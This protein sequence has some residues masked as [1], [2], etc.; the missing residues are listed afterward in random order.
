MSRRAASPARRDLQIKINLIQ[1]VAVEVRRSE[2]LKSPLMKKNQVVLTRPLSC[3][4]WCSSSLS[5]SRP[6]SGS[7]NSLRLLERKSSSK[8]NS[9]SSRC[10][11]RRAWVCSN[12]CSNSFAI[13]SISLIIGRMIAAPSAVTLLFP[14]THVPT[15]RRITTPKVLPKE[16]TRKADSPA[17]VI[18]SSPQTTIMSQTTRSRHASMM[19]FWLVMTLMKR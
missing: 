2:S 12:R 11:S 3:K 17:K 19:N 6:V 8:R 15:R 5:F 9:H 16:G 13:L 18:I 14:T 4:I 1:A 10:R 7:R